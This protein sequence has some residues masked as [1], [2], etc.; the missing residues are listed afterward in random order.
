MRCHDAGLDRSVVHPIGRLEYQVR[1]QCRGPVDEFAELVDLVAAILQ[2][3]RNPFGSFAF[4][5]TFWHG[6]LELQH[7]VREPGDLIRL[8][9]RE[10]IA[11]PTPTLL[12]KREEPRSIII[13]GTVNLP[14]TK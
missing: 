1:L 4:I 8:E 9:R 5:F 6:Q 12:P 3:L 2:Q 7:R 13:P 14:F 11:K 10:W